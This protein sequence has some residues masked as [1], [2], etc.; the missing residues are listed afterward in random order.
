VST[1]TVS[2]V[3]ARRPGRA[4]ARASA[5]RAGLRVRWTE[6]L[7][8]NGYALVASS[9]LTSVVGLAYWVVAAR[10]FSP[11]IVGLNAA[12][13]AAMTLLVAI[14]QLNLKSALNRFLPRAGR[15]S[16][17]FII[18]AYLIA[19]A[20][21]AAVSVVFIVGVDLWAPRLDFLHDRPE[22]IVWFVVATMA[23]TL[24][25]LQD[26]VLAGIRQAAWVP[27]ENFAF[28]VSKLVLLLAVAGT[29]PVFGVFV[30]WTLPAMALVVPVSLLLFR[31]LVPL[32]VQRTQGREKPVRSWGLWHYAGADY[33]AYVIWSGTIAGLPLVVLNV[34]GP[35]ANA[36]FYVSWLIAYSLYLI[37]SSMGMSMLAEASLEPSEVRGLWRRTVV[38]SARLVVPGALAVTVAAPL[39][40]G[41]MGGSYS[42]EGV[43]LLRLLAL[44][45]IPFVIVDARVTAA[46]AQNHMRVV[47]GTYAALCG[48]VLGLGVPL[49]SLIG[50]VGAGIAWLTAQSIVAG[51]ILA[52]WAV[53]TGRLSWRRP[54]ALLPSASKGLR[55]LRNRLSSRTARAAILERLRASRATAAEWD[56]RGHL[57]GLNDV[58]IGEVGPPESAAAVIKWARK[59]RAERSLENEERAL[60]RLQ[61]DTRLGEWRRLLPRVLAS[62][63]AAGRRY[64]AETR[65]EGEPAERLLSK[66]VEPDRLV[67]AATAA[68]APLHEATRAEAV[69]Q[70]ALLEDLVDRPVTELRSRAAGRSRVRGFELALEGLREELRG[71]LGGASVVTSRVHGDLCPANVLMSSDGEEVTGLVD[72]ENGGSRGLPET[73]LLHLEITTRMSARGQELGEVVGEMLEERGA[74]DR[75][76]ILLAWLHH[77]SG[78]IAKS[79][80][81]PNSRFWVHRNIDP[82]LAAVAGAGAMRPARPLAVFGAVPSQLVGAALGLTAAGALWVSA[83]GR[84]DPREMTDLG[85]L[86]VL[87]PTFYV[88]L[89]VLTVSFLALLRSAEGMRLRTPLLSAHVLALIAFL[90]ATPAIVYGTLRYPWAWKHVGIVDY[91]A[92]HGSVSPDAAYLSVYHNWPGFFSLNALFAEVGGIGDTIQLATWAPVLFNV[93]NFGALLFVFSA[94]TSDRRVAWLGS[95]LFFITNWVGQDYFSPQA[96]T[97]FLYL[98]V[99]G[100]VLRYLGRPESDTDQERRARSLATA[101]VVLTLVVIASSHALTSVMVT[102]ALAALVL[103]RVCT[104]RALPLISA[105]IVGLWGLLFAHDAIFNQG[106]S[107]LHTITFPW[108][109]AESN[110]TPVG[111]LSEGQHLVAMVSRGLVAAVVALA[112]IGAVTQLR[113]RHLD[114]R[115]VLLA[116]TP[117]LLFAGGSYDG[118]ILFRIYLFAVPFLA[119][120]AAQ[121]LIAWTDRSG[122]WLPAVGS[123]AACV[124]LL[125]AFLLPYYGKEHQNYFTPEE[126]TASKFLY[127]HAPPG[128]LLV[129]G[130]TNYPRQFQDYERFK[131]VTVS[132]EPRDSQARVLAHPAEVLDGWMTDDDHNG[133]FVIITRSQKADVSDMGVMPQGSLDRIESA[134]LH[135]PRIRVVFRNRDAIIF[136]P[137]SAPGGPVA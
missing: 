94:L 127:S 2:S 116:V 95:W 61:R 83:L 55:Q 14:A 100:V 4:A 3:A 54:A 57:N 37:S 85:L 64:L 28:S 87:P 58:A 81:Y 67:A 107:M 11:R 35:D 125:G 29:F 33:V 113:A 108:T 131:Y 93:L 77:V 103:A 121:A 114:R 90:H 13:I 110:L 24:F 71:R 19:V 40:L 104:V 39:I 75:A 6:S 129:D 137:A 17:K 132:D 112:A 102:V 49:M 134:L 53:G 124:A 18:G 122:S 91:I 48:L 130:T 98:V 60:R 32:H 43:T 82:V 119:F 133:G 74:R 72:W 109:Q 10:T 73:D 88:A 5:L 66:G 25:V 27:I 117:L 136:A 36:Y 86:S 56:F 46:R 105:A 30:S 120:L 62:G 78:N 96:F 135:S 26:S 20:V 65:V 70:G 76:P 15:A 44:S 63:T 9:V 34:L 1:E 68:I 92:R 47:V 128:A 41:V 8:R 51:V 45:A 69:V 38:E 59:L 22:L 101:F 123:T 12:L 84:I 126:V 50:V 23:W 42:A 21:T 106:T 16:A 97:F 7:Y 52:R 111:Q 118:E 99:V 80:R 31:R 115:V 79:D 89:G